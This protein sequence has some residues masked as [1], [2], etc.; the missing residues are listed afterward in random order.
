MS[1]ILFK[2]CV[3]SLT[4]HVKTLSWETTQSLL[5]LFEDVCP[6]TL[7]GRIDGEKMQSYK[8]IDNLNE[9]LTT[10]EKLL[11]TPLDP[12]V[13]ILWNN[14]KIPAIHTDLH[15]IIH[16]FDDV[17]CVAPDMWFFNITQEYVVEFHHSYGLAVGIIPSI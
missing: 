3:Q 8:K 12:S 1:T 4:P 7:E 2:E 9:I 11:S 16:N 13:Y 17:S 10:L 14:A 6:I 5:E 15:H